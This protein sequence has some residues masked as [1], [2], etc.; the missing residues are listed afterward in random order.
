MEKCISNN[1]PWVTLK[2]SLLGYN[3]HMVK[4]SFSVQFN[5]Y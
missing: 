2:K 1:A 3:M 4:P 5:H